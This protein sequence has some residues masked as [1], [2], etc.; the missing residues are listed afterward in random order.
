MPAASLNSRPPENLIRT[1]ASGRGSIAL[2]DGFEQW[3]S[4]IV[5]LCERSQSIVSGLESSAPASGDE[6]R[7]G[8]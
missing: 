5:W 3:T 6:Q 7:H 4:R 8:D 1:A 2:I